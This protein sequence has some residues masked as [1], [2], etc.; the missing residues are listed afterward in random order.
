MS[1]RS[2]VFL[3]APFVAACA[4]ILAAGLYGQLGSK[5]TD[6]PIHA[7]NV[8]FDGVNSGDYRQTCSVWAAA[9]SKMQACESGMT[10]QM[11]SAAMMGMFGGYR[12]VAH[13]EKMWRQPYRGRTIELATVQVVYLPYGGQKLTAHLVK[14]DGH[15]YV[16][17]V[18]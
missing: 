11:A 3:A 14:R 10:I 15:W 16:R 17:Y 2:R 13:S 9:R 5:T 1:R 18:V 12:V 7:T 8:F 6:T 4:I